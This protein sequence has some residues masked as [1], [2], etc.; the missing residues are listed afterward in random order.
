MFE[1]PDLDLLNSI[2][3]RKDDILSIDEATWR[4][5]S[6]AISVE[7]GDKNRK[8]FQKFVS[9]RCS[10]NIIWELSDED[11]KLVST[12]TKLKKM[13]FKHFKA[14]YCF[15]NSENIDLQLEVLKI[16]RRFF[17]DEDN[18]EIEKPVLIS[19]LQ[20]IVNKMPKEKSPGPDGWTRELFHNFSDIMGEDLLDVVEESR[21]TGFIPGVLNSTFYVV[22][23]KISK[24]EHFS[25]F[26]PIALCNFAYKV[27]SKIIAS[28]IKDKLAKCI[29]IEWFGFLKDRLIFD[30]VGTTQEC[31]HTANTMKQ[32]SIFLKLD[33][34]EAYDNVTQKFLIL[35]LDQIRLNLCVSQWIMGCITSV[36]MTVLVIG[37]PTNFFK[38]HRGLRQ[39]CALSPLLF[40]WVVEVFSRLL[41]QTVESVT[42]QGLKVP[43]RTFFSHLIFVDEVLILGYVKIEY[44]LTLNSTL[45]K[46][47]SAT[48]NIINYHKSVFLVQNIDPSFQHN[49]NAVFDINIEI[50]GQG[51]KYL[52]FFLKLNN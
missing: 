44:W 11:G 16:V 47:Y 50:L 41:T 34:K 42:F 24:G 49:L 37:V 38:C 14:R 52:G 12:D 40:L 10:H 48:G 22:I 9:Q 6:W 20:D 31:L 18:M 39:G 26:R 45:S 36:N 17:N 3:Q 7:K 51:M 4:L 27:I 30:A 13:Y 29:S 19:E 43:I 28:R 35:L 1:Q 21:N 25:D 5:R 8:Q 2:S 46:F 32:N 33:L 23:P 15:L